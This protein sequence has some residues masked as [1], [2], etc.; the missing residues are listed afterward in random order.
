[1]EITIS[2]YLIPP[3]LSLA[4]GLVLAIIALKKGGKREENRLFA[5][6][7]LWWTLLAPVFITHQLVDDTA[8]L[9][10]I[11][12]CVHFLYVYNPAI[13]LLFFYRIL[14]IKK[15]QRILVAF[16][17]SFL[18]S[19]TTP[20]DY[21][22]YGMHRFSWGYI[23]KGGIAFQVFGLYSIIIVAHCIHY[24]IIYLKRETNPYLR[25]K[26][27]YLCLSFGLIGVLTLLNIPAINGI[28][29]YPMGNFT[30]LGLGVLGYGILKHRLM[31]VKSV[32]L[33]T[34]IWLLVSSLILF[35]NF[36]LFIYIYPY[37]SVLGRMETFIFIIGWFALNAI[38]VKNVQPFIN[39]RFHKGSKNLDQIRAQFLEE[40]AFLQDVKSLSAAVRRVIDQ[41]LHVNA[42]CI[43]IRDDNHSIMRDNENRTITLTEKNTQWLIN[44]PQVVDFNLLE[45]GGDSKDAGVTIPS[46]WL[47]P[48][49]IY[50]I[51]LIRDTQV[52]GAIYL[53]EKEDLR[54]LSP[55]EELFLSNLK[56]SVSVALSNSRMYQSIADLKE[57]LE[58]QAGALQQ[59]IEER[60]SAEVALRASEKKYRLVADH[61]MDVIWILDLN[62]NRLSYVSPAVERVFGYT[63]E[64]ALGSS[65][66]QILTPWSRMRVISEIN[67]QRNR[68]AAGGDGTNWSVTMELE[69]LKKD[70]SRVWS[71]VVMGF[72]RDDKGLPAA[73]LGVARDI[74]ERRRAEALRVAKVEAEEANQAKSE[75]LANMSHELR[76]PLNHI[77]GFTELIV[78]RNFGPLTDKQEE[79]LQ[80][81]LDSSD[82]LLA[83]INDIL[84]L[85]KVEAGQM[86]LTVNEINIGDLLQNSLKMVREKAEKNDISISLTLNKL[87]IVM[88]A[89]ER[90]VKQILYNLLSNAIKFTPRGGWVSLSGD[91]IAG[92]GQAAGESVEIRVTDSGIGLTAADLEHVFEVFVQVEQ[93]ANRSYQGTGLGLPLTRRMTEL[94]GGRLW[95]ESPGLGKGCTFVCRLPVRQAQ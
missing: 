57:A 15:P 84:D 81:V 9:L 7:C 31:D 25:L 79:Y 91:T 20:S 38:Y 34:I 72:H 2:P 13:N 50:L 14:E 63:T 19:L 76:T 11:E 70:G 78:A 16:L 59:E 52:L 66:D 12:R 33:L 30:F 36:F 53:S 74:T 71:E 86:E 89:D 60:K 28:D 4:I 37:F 6:V 56:R 77:I 87:P 95:V 10:I 24:S 88:K 64:E 83:L 55:D 67:A 85:S 29:F 17:L 39:Q 69:H 47:Q 3:V 26:K 41:A 1:M 42:A 32:V 80:D 44:A 92:H 93:S 61:V 27:G 90:K 23:A 75:F 49:F 94:H 45:A 40:I 68:E 58:T 62:Q 46:E 54:P 82:H 22:F 35:P 43:F 21:Y 73:L 18:L 65:L 48:E 8:T 5:L 51:P